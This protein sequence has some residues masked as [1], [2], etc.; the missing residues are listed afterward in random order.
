MKTFAS[1]QPAVDFSRAKATKNHISYKLCKSSAE[2]EKLVDNTTIKSLNFSKELPTKVLIHG[3]NLKGTSQWYDPL[4]T[5]YFKK[6]PHN[7]ILIDWSKACSESYANTSA[8]TKLLGQYI[9]DFILSTG[10]ELDK[11]HIIGHSLGSHIAGFIGKHIFA[12]SG[13]KIFRITATDPA[14][15]GFEHPNVNE[16][17]RLDKIDATFV[18]VIHTNIGLYGFFD[19]IGHVDFYPNGGLDQPGCPPFKVDDTCSHRKSSA[20]LI[21]SVYE[22]NIMAT[23][24]SSWEEFLKGEENNNNKLKRRIVFGDNTDVKARGKFY[25]RI[26]SNIDDYEAMSA[27]L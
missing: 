16:N 8:N 2:P 22:T 19:S 27:K 14:A 11:V 10:I 25:L 23:E 5:A 1:T 3:W 7:I 6:S 15:P 12:K 13:N 9:G 17:N 24:S 26:E 4:K 21:K 20:Y 18:D